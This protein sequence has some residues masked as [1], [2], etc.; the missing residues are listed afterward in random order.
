M[1]ATTASSKRCQR[2][3]ALVSWFALRGASYTLHRVVVAGSL[4]SIPL[5]Q[6]AVALPPDQEM[7]SRE[8]VIVD[9]H[10]GSHIAAEGHRLIA[11]FPPLRHCAV[12]SQKT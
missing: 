11:D 1:Q 3:G 4:T 12:L 8:C 10:I 6:E 5:D 9:G 2:L 7:P